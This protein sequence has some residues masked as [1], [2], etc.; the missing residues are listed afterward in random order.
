MFRD[1]CLLASPN[2]NFRSFATLVELYCK[3]LID[4]T[5]FFLKE[6]V[7]RYLYYDNFKIQNC[8]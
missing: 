4:V 2:R 5:R 1:I 6:R 7:F 8:A 3:L